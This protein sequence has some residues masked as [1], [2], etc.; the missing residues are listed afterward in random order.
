MVVRTTSFILVSS[1]SVALS[2]AVGCGPGT[3]R[4]RVAGQVL[5]DGKPVTKGEITVAPAGKRAAFGTIDSEGRFTLTTYE[6]GDGT[7]LG[8]HSVAVHSGEFLDPMHKMWN[9]PK[10]YANLATSGLSL[11]VDGPTDSAVINL[12]WDG[13]KPFVET[14]QQGKE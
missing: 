10:K 11:N 1:L 4:V 13:G 5:I 8:T 14:I 3:E 12:S 6:P 2:C 7:T 9:V